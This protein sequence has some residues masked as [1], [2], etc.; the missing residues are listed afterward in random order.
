MNRNNFW[1]FV[2]VVLVILWSLYELYPPTGRD[3]LVVFREKASGRTDPAFTNIVQKAQELNRA[4]PERAYENLVAAIGTNDITTY[5]RSF[6]AEKEAH[7]TTHILNR[8]QREAAGRIHLGIDLQ[9][10]TSFLVEM[11]T[12]E[13]DKASQADVALSQ[14]V[15]VLRKR[16]DK[17]GVAEPVIQPQGKNRILVQ[18]PGLS[19][20][21][22]NAAKEAIQKAAFLE[23]RMVYYPADEAQRLMAEGTTVPGYVVMT[24]IK[25]LPNGTKQAERYLVKRQAE[26]K[27]GIKT[28]MVTRDNLGRPEISFT[29]DSAAAEKF[30][31]ITTE[32][33]GHQ[34]AIIL[35]GELQTAPVIKTAITG[36]NGVI[37]GDYSPQEA[38]M[39]QTVLENPLKAPLHIAESQSVGP[40]LGQ[41][42]IRS[43]VR[44]SI[45]GTLFVSAFMLLYYLIAGMVANVALVANI[46][47][48]LGV[49]CSID[50]TLTLPGI[51]GLV[52]T[53]GMAVDANVLIYERIREES[54]KGKSLRG[55]VA[56]GYARAFGTIFDSHVT[57]LISSVILIF[58]GTG[59]IKGFGVALTIGVAASLFT[60]LVVTRMIFDFLLDRGW[61][62]SI[63][64]FHLIPTSLKLDFM[65]LAKVAFITSW[66]LIAI[67]VGYGVYRPYHDKPLFGPDF[68]GGDTSTFEYQNQVDPALLRDALGKAGISDP[69]IQYQKEAGG[70][71][72]ETLRVVSPSETGDKVSKALAAFPDAKFH[73]A[74]QDHVGPTVGKE[75]QQSAIIASM[76]SLFG[77]LVYVAFR[78]EFSFAAGAVLAVIHDVL[79]TIGWYCLSGRQFDAT[80]V[81]AILTIIGFSTND[82]IVI[83]DRIREDLR[84][85][86]RG[87]F[88]EVMNQALNQTL[89]RT[90]I[91]SGTV[92]L[93][94]F[95]LYVFGGGAI[96]AFAFTF[97]IGII[98]GTYS[99]I[100]IAS[101][102]VLWW[103]KGQRPTIGASPVAV[104]NASP[105]PRP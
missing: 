6:E 58:M 76:L 47:I 4:A 38:F 55:A 27:G 35:D 89:S 66:V 70:A 93:A 31:E 73:V 17:F 98:T 18:L 51:A 62:K 54:A 50:T 37:E 90:I 22:Q 25:T 26:L 12:N 101:A 30:G 32:N 41:D 80:T 9:G 24:H 53:V 60:A 57:T 86:V 43:G 2:L 11:N 104:E 49:M 33:V 23:F 16:V 14:A 96:N 59:S 63:K 21:V 71:G 34:L 65:K 7:P 102:L 20:A 87:T 36:G 74:R 105:A 78:Y 97:L 44:A 81:A 68:V 13:L 5:F 84:M 8:L 39:L 56:A 103:H 10:G 95:S 19:A 3:L 67:G 94:T 61:L 72:R 77:I 28:A 91:T 29:F 99:S 88:R 64:M 42:A 79:M 1:R 52:L 85:G 45:Y 82:T 40:T 15:E 46:V 69:V 48:L 92:F 100:Y 83:F 75:I